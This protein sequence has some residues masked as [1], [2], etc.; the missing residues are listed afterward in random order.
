[1]RENI[2]IGLRQILEVYRLVRW[3][4]CDRKTAVK[5]V[6]QIHR[7]TSRTIASAITKN[8]GINTDEFDDFLQSQNAESFCRKLSC[9]S[10]ISLN[11]TL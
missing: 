8:I 7:V 6:A 3:S 9:F 5:K 10:S 2:L 4:G 1:M 11:N